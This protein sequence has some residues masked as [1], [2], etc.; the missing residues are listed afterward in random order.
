LLLISIILK[1]LVTA[2][3][4]II[5]P[6]YYVIT[7]KWRSGTNALGDWMY[8]VALA[9]DQTGNV[10]GG[11]IFEYLFTKRG[12]N[13]HPFSSEDDTVSYCLARNKY[14]NNL[15]SAGAFLAS[16]LD[17]IDPSDG[18]HM[19]KAIHSKIES[20]EDALLRMQENKY[21]K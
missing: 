1:Y 8:K 19:S 2:V 3:A 12:K 20:D 21:F 4:F 16:L 7:L 6:V 13:S 15:S 5:T 18:G 9:N 14:K 11:V 10:I 17:T